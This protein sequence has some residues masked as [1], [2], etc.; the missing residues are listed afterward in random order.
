[1][2]KTPND[3]DTG[4]EWEP[5]RR[6]IEA[7]QNGDLDAL[8]L[9]VDLRRSGAREPPWAVGRSGGIGNC[10]LHSSPFRH[11]RISVPKRRYTARAARF[12]TIT[13][14]ISV[15]AAAQARSI[16]G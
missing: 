12:S 1:M 2:L 10:G 3:A 4:S 5:E 8:G 11:Y 16:A 13:I 9:A 6:I 15:S 7:A 14:T